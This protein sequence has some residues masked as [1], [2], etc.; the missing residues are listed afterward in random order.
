MNGSYNNEITIARELVAIGIK[1]ISIPV[2]ADSS[3]GPPSHTATQ[4]QLL[5][6]IP[7][8]F[9]REINPGNLTIGRKQKTRQLAGLKSLYNRGNLFRRIPVLS[10]PKPPGG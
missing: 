1:A 4:G 7:L 9:N 5:A 6:S 10:A 3:S 8:L 2:R